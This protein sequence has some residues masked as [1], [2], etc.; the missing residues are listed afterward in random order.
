MNLLIVGA[1]KGSWIMRGQQLGAALGARVTSDPTE[2]D[3]RWADLVI[4]VKRAG[5]QWAAAVHRAHKP[6]VWDALDCWSQPAQ[7]RYTESQALAFFRQQIAV[8]RPTL[9]IGATGAMARACDGVYLPHHSWNGLVPTPARDS[10]R[11]VAYEGNPV[12]L[13]AWLPALQQACRRRG[14]TFTVNP[15]S[16]AD[17]DL[18]VAFRDGPWDG[19]MC[20][21]WKSG[22][23]I[24][25]AIAAGRPLISQDSSANQELVPAGCNLHTPAELDGVLEACTS[26]EAR[27][28]TVEHCR[29]LAPSYTLDAVAAQYRTILEQRVIACAA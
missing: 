14:W 26:H 12:Y 9:T 1:G 10:V 6:L 13:G 19:W 28:V 23:K 25:N 18:I 17:A 22:V 24:V 3:F 2:A 7:N 29:R 16:L 20:R 5:L 8:I 4:L 15:P 21:E 11:A 27:T